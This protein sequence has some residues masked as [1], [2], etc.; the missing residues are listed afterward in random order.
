MKRFALIFFAVFACSCG[1][2]KQDAP[3]EVSN[4]IDLTTAFHD[5]REVR[6]SELVDSISFVILETTPQSNVSDAQG[7]RFSGDYIFSYDKFFN[8]R[9]KYLGKVGMGVRGRGPLE[10]PSG[11]LGGIYADGYFYNMGTKLLQ[12]DLTG[13]TTGKVRNFN[14]P[15]QN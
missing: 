8:W 15:G 9:G 13:K 12:F 7:I 2:G 10:E 3:V 1:G 6:L 14:I 11:A 5:P 4:I